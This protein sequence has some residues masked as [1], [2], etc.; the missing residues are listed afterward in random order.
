MRIYLQTIA[1]DN[2]PLRFYQ[3]L[4]LPDLLEGWWLIRE[5]GVQ[6]KGGRSQRQHFPRHEAALAAMEMMRDNQLKR[7]YRVVFMEGEGPTA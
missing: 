5:W 7:G 2:Q 1:G 4:L 3:L 6:G